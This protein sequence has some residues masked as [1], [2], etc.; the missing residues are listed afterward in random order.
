MDFRTQVT[1]P[2]AS[3]RFAADALLVLVVGSLP[4]ALAGGE[5]A[6]GPADRVSDDRGAAADPAGGAGAGS[7]LHPNPARRSTT[8]GAR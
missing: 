6:T 4:G 2:G 1:G 7:R 8:S 3:S 5:G